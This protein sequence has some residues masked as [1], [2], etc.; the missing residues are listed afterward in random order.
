LWKAV[1]EDIGEAAMTH[2]LI[3]PA[4]NKEARTLYACAFGKGVYKSVDGGK[5]WR[6][7][8]NGIAGNEPFA[9]RIFRRNKDGALFLIVNRRSEDGGI[10]NAGDGALY[11]SDDGAETWVPIALPS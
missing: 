3:D 7:K 5:T 10:S 9:W 1:S 8:N 4:S 2:V 11:R 6:R